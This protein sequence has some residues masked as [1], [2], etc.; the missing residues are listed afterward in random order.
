MKQRTNLFIL[1][2]TNALGSKK[3]EFHLL[4]PFG[5]EGDCRQLETREKKTQKTA[6]RSFKDA[7]EGFR[8]LKS[9]HLTF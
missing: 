7:L 4:Q 6:H 3:K 5:N 1:V 2:R 9:P 8:F